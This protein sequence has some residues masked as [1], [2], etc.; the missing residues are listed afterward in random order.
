LEIEGRL[1]VVMRVT[2]NG[3]TLIELSVLLA[4]IALGVAYI[5]PDFM[6]KARGDL[7]IRTAKEMSMIA[8]ASKWYYMNQ[9]G[10]PAN[11]DDMHWPGELAGA[12]CI[13][14]GTAQNALTGGAADYLKPADFR[15]PW[16]VPYDVTL[17][18]AG[19][20][21]GCRLAI[22]TNV[23]TTVAGEIMTY[24]PMATCDGVGGAGCP[25][26]AGGGFTRCCAKIVR[27]GQEMMLQQWI[28]P[29]T[30]CDIMK[31]GG[32]NSGLC[33]I[34]QKFA[35]HSCYYTLADGS[36][37]EGYVANGS[38]RSSCGKYCEETRLK[39]C[40]GQ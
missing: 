36:C 20:S 18:N 8:D 23:P 27:P 1:E 35:L 28:E 29:G 26:G 13:P 16:G 19:V 9:G 24:M 6:E 39:C 4:V 38:I 21:E 40:K 17:I 22:A 33:D 5:A 11:R 34:R 32:M 37:N 12:N 15:N 7:A 2:R 25:G 14:N 30:M 10:D 31:G 3:F